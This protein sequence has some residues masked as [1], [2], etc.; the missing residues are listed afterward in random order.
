MNRCERRC[1]NHSAVERPARSSDTIRSATLISGQ[2]ALKLEYRYSDYDTKDVSLGFG[3]LANIANMGL[4]ATQH[5]VRLGV[6]Y[7]FGGRS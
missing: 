7:R 5:S 2:L 3:P 6:S 1:L 4:D